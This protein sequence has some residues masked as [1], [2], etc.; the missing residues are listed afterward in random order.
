[1][2]SRLRVQ[3]EKL[4]CLRLRTL[5]TSRDSTER[6]RYFP[7]DPPVFSSRTLRDPSPPKSLSVL[8]F[9][10]TPS[11]SSSSSLPFRNLSCRASTPP[12]P[13]SSGT[14]RGSESAEDSG[15]AFDGSVDVKE[16][17]NEYDLTLNIPRLQPYKP[18]RDMILTARTVSVPVAGVS[19]EERQDLVKMMRVGNAVILEQ[20]PVNRFDPFAVAVYTV[21]GEKLGYV[22][23]TMTHLFRQQRYALGVVDSVGP[24]SSM[25]EEEGEEAAA[26]NLKN[27]GGET[28]TNK[29]TEV[30]VDDNGNDDSQSSSW[31]DSDKVDVVRNHEQEDAGLIEEEEEESKEVL[32]YLRVSVKPNLPALTIDLVPKTC[33]GTNLKAELPA[34]VWDKARA[35]VYMKAD[36]K[37]EVCGDKG[38]KWPVEC[39]EDYHYDEISFSRHK[40]TL[41][42]LLALCPACHKVKHAGRCIARAAAISKKADAQG[43]LKLISQQLMR[44]NRWTYNESQMYLQHVF[45]VW[46]ER[47]VFEWEQDFSWLKEKMDIDPPEEDSFKNQEWEGLLGNSIFEDDGGNDN[48]KDQ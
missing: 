7:R 34:E 28:A 33:W 41:A 16:G 19:F 26:T 36:Y 37:C 23:K 24:I 9:S 10:P 45:S 17:K 18:R 5:L 46:H 48:D 35:S 39:Q 12:P 13:S 1:M 6:S 8:P 25:N 40:Q 31:T 32:W 42:G 20:E 15:V 38:S 11:S 30:V 14:R 21:S 43:E 22:P 47:S 27:A 44:V 2:Q 4:L 3:R 29:S